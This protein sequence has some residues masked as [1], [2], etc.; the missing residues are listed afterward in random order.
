[1]WEVAIVGGLIGIM[2]IWAYMSFN[3]GKAEGREQEHVAI[4]LLLLLMTFLF[5]IPTLWVM[6][7]IANANDTQLGNLFE[8]MF[9]AWVL[10]FL[11]LAFYYVIIFGIF[12]INLLRMKR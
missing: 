10:I 6:R 5:I 2:F 12:T 9:A 11:F 1:M 4:R 8:A 7:T 3:I